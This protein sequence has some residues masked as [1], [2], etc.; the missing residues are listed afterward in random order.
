M[1]TVMMRRSLNFVVLMLAGLLA[2]ACTLTQL[3][4]SNVGLAY[5]NAPPMLGW[6]VADYVD[7]SDDQKEFVRERVA[8]VFA[9]H[10]A[11]ELPEYRRFLEKVLAQAE[12]NLSVDEA[13]LDH[14]ELRSYYHRALARLLPDMADFFLQLD[15]LQVKQ[16]ERRF[17]KD[18]RKVVADAND[19]DPHERQEK[20][21]ERLTTHL[22]Q[23]TEALSDSQRAMVDGYASAQSE[24]IDERLADRRYRQAGILALVRS[25][26]PRDEAITEL[27][28]LFID[29]ESWRSPDYQRKLR[30]RD[31]QMFELIARLSTSLTPEQRAA[32]QRRVRGFLRDITEITASRN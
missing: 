31:R 2:A 19:G 26:P 28:R 30:M 13:A 32:F 9:W 27:R 6:M 22:E 24:L 5:N 11:E 1:I 8:R 7:M 17:N 3:A 23:F 21:A 20:R 4:Y 18:N 14:R 12:D 25:K 16:M 10:R 29:T 15:S